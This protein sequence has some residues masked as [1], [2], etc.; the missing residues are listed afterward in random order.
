[1]E[2]F[3]VARS[4]KYILNQLMVIKQTEFT[5]LQKIKKKIIKTN[6]PCFLELSTY[7]HY[8]HCGPN[9][10]DDLGYRNPKVTEKWKK[11]VQIDF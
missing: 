2:I 7:R 1:M 10:D 6:K 5:Q 4:Q 11:N 9:F 8:E 3:K